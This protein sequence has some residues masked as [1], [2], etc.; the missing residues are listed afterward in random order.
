MGSMTLYGVLL[1]VMLWANVEGG[2][3]DKLFMLEISLPP[4]LGRN[5]ASDISAIKQLLY[6]TPGVTVTYA[7]KE[8][9]NPI[10]IA[11]VEV[12]NDCTW[13]SVTSV[14]ASR[15]D[16]YSAIP[17]YRCEDFARAMNVTLNT[18]TKEFDNV[19][20]FLADLVFYAEGYT[21]PEYTNIL[22]SHLQITSNLLQDGTM[23]HCYRDMGD[24]PIRMFHFTEAN[25]SDND[26][27]QQVTKTSERFHLDV[28]SY[29]H[30]YL[31][32]NGCPKK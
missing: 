21:T 22:K 7:L 2:K 3:D 28:R 24:V 32:P 4:L 8:V 16:K 17:L 18:Q 14:L 30:L 25:P 27:L 1:C 15:G 10:I 31:Y 13:A 19:T 23:M 11:V 12:E 26:R 20:I 9:G 29:Q 5:E 6:D